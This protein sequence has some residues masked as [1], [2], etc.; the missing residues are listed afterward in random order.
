MNENKDMNQMIIA[1]L[2]QY[3]QQ[4]DQLAMEIQRGEQT[5]VQQ[6]QS[7]EQL[8]GAYGA[9]WAMA[10]TAGLVNEKGEIVVQPEAVPTE[11]VENVPA[12]EV[13]EVPVKEVGE[14]DSA[15]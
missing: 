7:Y 3:Q 9:M 1:N 4:M 14:P 12:E 10:Q 13:A 6:K 11:E 8:R 15:E 2:T 5:L